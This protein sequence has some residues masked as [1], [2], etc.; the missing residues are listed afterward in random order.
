MNPE[1]IITTILLSLLAFSFGMMVMGAI[2]I[3]SE[4]RRDRRLANE[5]EIWE[6]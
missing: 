3:V 1:A 6:P 5:L 4:N 2:A